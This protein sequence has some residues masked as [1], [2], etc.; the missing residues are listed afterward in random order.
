MC[1]YHS[2]TA[3]PPSAPTTARQPFPRLPLPQPDS[4]SPVCPYNNQTAFPSCAPTTAR[5]P[6]PRLPLPWLDNPSLVCPYHSQ[7]ALPPSASTTARQSFNSPYLIV[8]F[9]PYPRR[10]VGID[11]CHPPELAAVAEGTLQADGTLH[12]LFRLCKE[13]IRWCH[14]S[15]VMSRMD[16]LFNRLFRIT[17]KKHQSSRIIDPLSPNRHGVSNHL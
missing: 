6:F 9:L 16:C 8:P 10:L 2:Q 5:Q 11:R 15:A 14:L 3:L 12:T 7:T 13:T 4:P 1:P 17:R